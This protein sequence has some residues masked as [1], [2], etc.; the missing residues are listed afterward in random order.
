[1]KTNLKQCKTEMNCPENKSI[2]YCSVILSLSH[3]CCLC[4][5]CDVFC[6]IRQPII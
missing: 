3:Y 4:W 2:S 6:Y 5:F 1:M